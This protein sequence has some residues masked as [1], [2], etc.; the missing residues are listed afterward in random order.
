MSDEKLDLILKALDDVSPKRIDAVL[1]YVR[2]QR[3]YASKSSDHEPVKKPEVKVRLTPNQTVM[4]GGV[5]AA[6]LL[7]KADRSSVN[8]KRCI[9][10]DARGII[11]APTFPISASSREVSF[12]ELTPAELGLGRHPSM[13]SFVTKGF[14]ERWSED[15]LDGC[16]LRLCEPEDAP[17]LLTQYTGSPKGMMTH[18]AMPSQTDAHKFQCIFR[19]GGKDKSLIILDSI[20]CHPKLT[21]DRDSYFVFRLVTK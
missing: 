6:Q 11:T 3:G 5:S 4:I 16:E 7:E 15:N 10:Y 20:A 8:A 14:C 21:F 1:K 9:L 17:Q 12:V 2:R 13:G 19:F 18:F